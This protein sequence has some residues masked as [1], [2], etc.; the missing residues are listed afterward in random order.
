MSDS[1]IEELRALI[2]AQ[3]DALGDAGW[4]E[5]EVPKSF[6]ESGVLRVPRPPFELWA[7]ARSNGS[8]LVSQWRTVSPVGVK[9]G[10]DDPYHT[11]WMLGAGLQPRD[12]H[13]GGGNSHHEALSTAAYRARSAVEERLLGFKASVL[14]QGPPVRGRVHVPEGP[15]DLPEA[16]DED[17]LPPV[18]VLR[19]AEARWLEIAV[20]TLAAGGAVIV[21]RGGEMAHLVVELR[22][23]DRGPIMQVGK[24]RTLYKEGSVVDIDPSRGMVS[25]AEDERLVRQAAAAALSAPAWQELQP[26]PE[27]EPER[28][29]RKTPKTPSQF[30]IVEATR[31]K[32]QPTDS[33]AYVEPIRKYETGLF[34][35]YATMHWT[36]PYQQEGERGTLSLYAYRKGSD[37]SKERRA[38]YSGHRAWSSQDVVDACREVADIVDPERQARVERFW[39]EREAQRR[40]ERDE[41]KER[42]SAMSDA[43]LALFVEQLGTDE[44]EMY[45]EYFRGELTPGD[46]SACE[47]HY[48]NAFSII[49]EIVEDRGNPFVVDDLRPV[50]QAWQAE[51]EERRAQQERF[52]AYLRP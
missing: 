48:R 50:L 34:D 1:R 10:A 26:A 15:D 3:A 20:A 18:S 37:S 11:D 12:M 4:M 24:A 43:E 35:I 33:L 45:A 47:D 28:P 38:F 22:A 32:E 29:A 39:R 49:E 25:L 14:L 36:R 44:D 46:Y 9:Q 27:P 31:L 30:G 51:E 41:A 5:I 8:H 17:G 23:T 21:E 40:R 52:E 13:H 2:V 6:R 19:S 42:W 7:V 16:R